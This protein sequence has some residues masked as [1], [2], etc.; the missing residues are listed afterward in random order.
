MITV[1]HTQM[2]LNACALL[3]RQWGAY[4][5]GTLDSVYPSKTFYEERL[6]EGDDGAEPFHVYSPVAALAMGYLQSENFL[7]RT[8]GELVDGS[9]NRFRRG[10]VSRYMHMA[11]NR[12]LK[13]S[14][15]PK[16]FRLL[17]FLRDAAIV[18]ER[19]Q[20]QAYRGG[21]HYLISLAR[22]PFF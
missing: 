2:V 11:I 9:F 3:R 12:V 18:A 15:I 20:A 22:E 17:I 13:H 6:V 5:A 21:H 7:F 4:V 16:D 19:K 8:E 14:G 10:D 1:L